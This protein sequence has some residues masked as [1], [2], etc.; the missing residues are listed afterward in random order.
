VWQP[1]CYSG[2]GQVCYFDFVYT[3]H[4]VSMSALQRIPPF[5]LRNGLS[6]NDWQAC[7][8]FI[9][10]RYPD[11]VVE[12]A[13]CQGGCSYTVLL[14]RRTIRRDHDADGDS[15]EAFIVQIRPA[16]HAISPSIAR[17]ARVWYGELAPLFEELIV[18][19][20][21]QICRMSL[22]PGVRLSDVLPT[23][24]TVDDRSRQQLQT[25]L[26]S[27]VDFHA[28]AWHQG[29]R[30]MNQRPES[31]RCTGRVG[32][33]IEQRL[34]W[35]ESGLPTPARRVLARRCRTDLQNGGLDVLPVVLTH[36]DLL[37]SN[38]MVDS[39][40]WKISGMV[41]WAEAE[42]LPFGM[43]LYCVDHLLGRLQGPNKFVWYDSATE[44][45]AVFWGALWKRIPR[46]DDQVVQKAVRLARDIG[47]LLWHGIA[48]DDGRIDRVVEVGQDDEELAYLSAF[49]EDPEG[50][51]KALL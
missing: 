2:L 15:L 41:D 11:C 35:L 5:A 46:L 43:S 38:I 32:S 44:L 18:R 6:A 9:Q 49:V 27:L 8:S 17:D 47:V 33:T 16:K 19:A 50:I 30:S 3:R 1:C 26:D 51:V 25:L 29:R 34:R 21:V 23:A 7:L 13:R 28:C 10:E 14:R 45:R 36:G 24:N 40:T 20:G 37:P 48:F 12:E 39:K 31:R 4:D 42:Y 22:L